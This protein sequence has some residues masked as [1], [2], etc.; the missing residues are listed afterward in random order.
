MGSAWHCF[1]RGLVRAAPPSKQKRVKQSL[2]NS[3]LLLALLCA[4]CERQRGAGHAI[5]GWCVATKVVSGGAVVDA[6]GCSGRRAP[7]PASASSSA[8]VLADERF[9]VFPHDR[10][11]FHICRT[12]F[13]PYISGYSFFE[14]FCAS[15]Q[16]TVSVSVSVQAAQSAGAWASARSLRAARRRRGCSASPARHSSSKQKRRVKHSAS[17]YGARGV[18]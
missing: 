12:P 18:A 16:T 13:F 7:A 8:S 17:H 11:L 10:S 1:R 5:G 2:S 15:Q 6:Y 9:F 3:R 14:I 4:V